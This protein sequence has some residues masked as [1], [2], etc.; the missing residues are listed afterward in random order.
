MSLSSLPIRACILLLAMLAGA[1]GKA[2]AP[3]PPAVSLTDGSGLTPNDDI[4]GLDAATDARGD[5]HVVWR[6]RSNVYGGASIHARLVYRHGSGTP[7]HWGPRVVV[8]E[9][10]LAIGSAKVIVAAD[11]V[12]VFAGARMHHWWWPVARGPL[13]NQEDMLGQQD[14]A[15]GVFDAIETANGIMLAYLATDASDDQT[16]RGLRWSHTGPSRVFDI[17]NIPRAR[18]AGRVAPQLHQFGRRLMLAWTENSL[19]E[20]WDKR[21]NTTAIS[22]TTTIHSTW[23]SDAGATWTGVRDVITGQPATIAALALAG[24]AEMPVALFATSCLFESRL[25]ANG[26]TSPLR[27]AGDGSNSLSG[28][29][30]TSA[31][32]A[33]PCNDHSVVAWVDARNRL[34]DRRWWNPLGGFPWGDNPDWYNNDLFIAKNAPQSSGSGPMLVSLRLTSPGSFTREIVVVEHDGQ[35][36]VFRTGRARVHKAPDDAGAA[37]EVTQLGVPC[38]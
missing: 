4:D 14:P 12:H 5:V 35:L 19:Q 27:I 17:A 3:P 6:E 2:E 28:S 15:V 30:E 36:L 23:S 26:W 37:P 9:G 34:S 8:A 7:L 31:V 22:A 20:H 29:G 33:I 38:H 24:K 25:G 13:N 21:I 16:V 18:S 10:G 11:L 32:A 1:C